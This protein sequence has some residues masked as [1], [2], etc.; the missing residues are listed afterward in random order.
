MQNFPPKPNQIK[1]IYLDHAAATPTDPRV[2][3]T[4]LPFF[5]KNF[6]N[7]SS[8]YS[9]GRQAREA[10][11]SA[12]NS[13]AEIFFTQPDTIFFTSGG[14]EANNLAL[15]GIVHAHK[16]HGKHIITTA[17]EHYSILNP[18]KQLEQEGFEITYLPVTKTGEISC[19]Q[20]QKNIRPDTILISIMRVNNEIG[21]INP[22]ND[23]G[24]ALLKWRKKNNTPYPYF[25]SDACQAAGVDLHVE[26]LHVDLLTINSSKI[27]GPKGVGALY[28]RRG[29]EIVPLLFGGNQ[30]NGLR[31]GTENVPG[32]A[33]MATA[34][35]L[36]QSER[37]KESK[38]LKKLR[39]YFWKKIRT[40]IKDVKLNGPNLKSA[41]LSSNLNVCFK[42]IEGEALV[43]YLDEYGI[44]C[45]TGSACASDLL[46]FSHVLKAIGLS[47][48]ETRGSL[49]FTLGKSTKKQDIDYVM[50][51]L[52]KVVEGL[53]IMNKIQF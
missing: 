32:I 44:T 35:D 25:H 47:E 26:R 41:R 31:S 10:V 1:T 24:R 30:E 22:I 51:Y 33:G 11:E 37:E 45:A 13:V 18:L 52:P 23:I 39:D 38:R 29:V 28:K 5:T 42:G 21:T 3:K 9:L 16:K 53:R 36:I 8:L 46:E 34:L 14:A 12:R 49:R 48:E 17:I 27:Y 40:K 6:G 19:A 50:K 15:F 7:A 20:L 2:I 4:M 43:L